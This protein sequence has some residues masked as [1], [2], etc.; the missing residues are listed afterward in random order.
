MEKE[1]FIERYRKLGWEFKDVMPGKAIRV[2]TLKISNTQLVGRLME[3]EFEVSKIPFLRN[4]FLVQELTFSIGAITEFLLGYYYT[5]EAASQ[6]ASEVLNPKPADLVLDM[7]AAP[8]G[9]TTHLAQLMKNRGVIVALDK[10]VNR[11]IALKNNI[12]RM[13][14][15]N[16]IAF[17][18]NSRDVARLGIKFDKILLDAPCAGNFTQEE[19]WFGKREIE[20]I[21]G[22]ARMQRKLLEAAWSVL[23]DGG[24]LVYSTC[25]LE[26]EENEENVQ[27]FE[28]RVRAKL[29]MMER[30]WPSEYNQGFFIAKFR[31][32][33]RG[34]NGTRI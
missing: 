19:D 26:P 18:M 15:S 11:L 27:W 7:A 9:K 13:G 34:E 1:F 6:R 20:D 14:V 28:K 31:K 8:G 4:G 30:M 3:L 33:N 12:E 2:N 21:R 10:N 5:Q 17:N 25:S 29:V 24:E 23:K 32:E 22:I 16:V